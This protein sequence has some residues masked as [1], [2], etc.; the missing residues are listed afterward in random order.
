MI[1]T[2]RDGE[3]NIKPGQIPTQRAYVHRK[4][5]QVT[6]VSGDAFDRL[7]N[8]FA[9]VARTACAGCQRDVWPGTVVWEDTGESIAAYRRR[10]RRAAPLS[11]KLCGWGTGPLLG[12]AAGWAVGPHDISKPILGAFI[13]FIAV[14]FFLAPILCRW[15][16]KIDY[17]SI[18]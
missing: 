15:V 1:D 4:C 2:V 7:S 5:G 16:W 11:L 6:L 12:A 3:S 9:F 14:T 18:P 13:G 10:L 8:P 17:R